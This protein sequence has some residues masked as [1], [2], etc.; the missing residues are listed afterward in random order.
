MIFPFY[1]ELHGIAEQIRIMN[2]INT[3]LVQHLATINPSLATVLVS[4]EA[5][6]SC[7]SHQ[8][9]DQDSQNRNSAGQGHLTRN[10]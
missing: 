7:R 6:L 1:R 8:S 9:G 2:E 10:R 4:E 3:R 5:D